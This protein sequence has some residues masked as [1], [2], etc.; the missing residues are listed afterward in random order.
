MI[1]PATLSFANKSVL[2][3]TWNVFSPENKL[4][5]NIFVALWKRINSIILL[6]IVTTVT[7]AFEVYI[8][9]SANTIVD[10]IKNN[11]EPKQ[12]IAMGGINPLKY[13]YIVV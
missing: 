1:V 5:N 3:S 11:T 4:K 13:I 8:G 6:G 2:N 10:A 12:Q 9:M 7:G